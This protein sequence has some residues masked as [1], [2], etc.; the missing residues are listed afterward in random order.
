MN[1][2]SVPQDLL[3]ALTQVAHNFGA[4]TVAGGAILARWPVQQGTSM[5]RRFAWWVLAGWVVQGVSGAIFGAISMAFYGR[6]P[7]LQGV[8]WAA[9]LIK[10][11]CA[12]IGFA[13]AALYLQCTPKRWSDRQQTQAWNG[14]IVLAATALTAA[15][16]LRWFA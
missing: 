13:L 1:E 10:M 2:A 12:V 15:A 14:M 3:Y 6:L 9:L 4:M 5:R 11:A 16:F 7:D 8:A